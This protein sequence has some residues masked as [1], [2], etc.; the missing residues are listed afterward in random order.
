MKQK[1]Y[2]GNPEKTKGITKVCGF[3]QGFRG[4]IIAINEAKHEAIWLGMNGDTYGK[5]YLVKEK[6]P[7]EWLNIKNEV[8]CIPNLV[9]W[10]I[11]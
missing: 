2:E 10:K 5:L 11:L 8:D 4:K 6:N 7:K 3:Q 9:G 1:W